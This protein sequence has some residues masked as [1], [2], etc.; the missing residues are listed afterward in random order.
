MS[1]RNEQGTSLQVHDLTPLEFFD[2]YTTEEL[3]E[4]IPYLRRYT[5]VPEE[6]P[7]F[8]EDLARKG[9][10][11]I[12]EGEVRIVKVV[13]EEHG[14][15]L[16]TL[17]R[18]EIF[19]EASMFDRGPHTST[20]EAGERTE[21]VAIT[22]EVYHEQLVKEQPHLAERIARHAA[23]VLS[24]RLRQA[25]ETVMTYAIWTRSL[26]QASPPTRWRW[27]PLSTTSNLQAR[28]LD[29]SAGT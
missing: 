28:D 18:G 19:G 17:R 25:N 3:R 14:L 26:Q 2:G 5:Y 16:A 6:G 7:I 4:L 27:Y 13:S 9:I 24:E 11:L 12:L 1:E 8:H 21:T 10:Q 23:Q 22:R 15:L 20:V 29:K